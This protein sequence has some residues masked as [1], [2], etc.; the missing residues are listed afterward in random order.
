MKATVREGGPQAAEFDLEL[1]TSFWRRT[2]GL[3]GRRGL[4]PATGLLIRPCGSVHTFGM[5]FTIDAVYLDRDGRIVKVAP[6]LR[7][8][9]LSRGGRRAHATLELAAGEADRLGMTPGARV[10]W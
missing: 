9:R 7:P 2:V 8:W 6:H 10:D 5:R 3:L 1:A 4:P